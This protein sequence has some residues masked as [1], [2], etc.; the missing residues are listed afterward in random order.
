MSDAPRR[1]AAARRWLAVLVALV[2]LALPSAAFG[3]EETPGPEAD[4]ALLE[5]GQRVYGAVCAGCHQAGGVGLE[6][7]FPALVDNPRVQDTTYVEGV[8]RSTTPGGRSTSGPCL[9][10]SCPVHTNAG[11]YVAAIADGNDE[12]PCLHCTARLPRLTLPQSLRLRLRTGVRRTVRGRLP[13][14]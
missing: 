9:A 11:M 4:V 10:A 8:I 6:G 3:Q 5:E 7:A 1:G 14:G 13:A 2:A 12:L